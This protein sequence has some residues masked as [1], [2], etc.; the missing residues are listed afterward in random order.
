MG[1]ET[2]EFLS[3][4]LHYYEPAPAEE[5]EAS[6][7][8]ASADVSDPIPEPEPEAYSSRRVTV[9]DEHNDSSFRTTALIIFSVITLGV[10][11]A[12]F[13]VIKKQHKAI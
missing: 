13:V 8:K 3:Q 2:R 1:S 4:Y 10:F 9:P 11:I 12:V 7:D 5:N 6:E